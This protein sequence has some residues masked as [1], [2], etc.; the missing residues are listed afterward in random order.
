MYESVLPFLDPDG[1]EPK[2]TAEK[3]KNE[4]TLNVFLILKNIIDEYT[5]K[6]NTAFP[7]VNIAL[8]TSDLALLKDN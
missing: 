6:H 7:F 3:R 5:S 8:D 1:S 4:E 2:F